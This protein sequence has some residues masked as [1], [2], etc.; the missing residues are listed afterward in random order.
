MC[1][2]T[3]MCT[4]ASLNRM[5]QW[6]VKRPA[7][8]RVRDLLLLSQR[9][10]R[11]GSRRTS[12]KDIHSLRERE[13]E[14][15]RGEEEEGK[16]HFPINPA[17]MNSQ[18]RQA[19]LVRRSRETVLCSQWFFQSASSRRGRCSGT[20][21]PSAPGTKRGSHTGCSPDGG[22]DTLALTGGDKEFVF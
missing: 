8:C 21:S 9:T 4:S 15:R 13:R 7:F 11:C 2:F 12:C 3:C 10:R 14:K 16:K 1:L 18:A 19:W 5:N 17:S 6:L 22:T 20:P